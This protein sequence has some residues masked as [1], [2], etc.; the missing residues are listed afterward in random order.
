MAVLAN[1]AHVLAGNLPLPSH[2]SRDEDSAS[3]SE[4]GRPEGPSQAASDRPAARPLADRPPADPP[5]AAGSAPAEPLEKSSSSGV[6]SHLWQG[7]KILIVDD[8]PTV[9][10]FTKS[11]LL[12]H[13]YVVESADNIWISSQVSTFHPDMILMDVHLGASLGTAAVAALRNRSFTKKILLIL[14]S[15]L[16]L[17][18]L[19]KLAAECGADGVIPKRSDPDYLVRQVRRC[20]IE[21]AIT[22]ELGDFR[23]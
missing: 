19:E 14:Y 5:E 2:R 13:G 6:Y 17:D 7:K 15:T 1:R 8:S 23:R 12:R 21:A 11:V 20:F 16:D 10:V 4:S 9:T 18:Q 3:S 22:A